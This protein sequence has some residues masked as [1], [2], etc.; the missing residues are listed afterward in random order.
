MERIK[1]VL[2][3]AIARF[4]VD[5]KLGSELVDTKAKLAERKTIERAQGLLMERLHLSEDEAYKRLRKQAMERKL[6][7]VELA[8]RFSD[9]A[10]LLG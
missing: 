7:L 6:K 5:Q 1:Q 2:D 10:D 3:V 4:N 9:A 8:Q